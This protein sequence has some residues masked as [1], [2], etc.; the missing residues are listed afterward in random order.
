MVRRTPRKGVRVGAAAGEAAGEASWVLGAGVLAGGAGAGVDRVGAA[1]A[2]GAGEVDRG[3]SCGGTDVLLGD[4]ACEAG[5]RDGVDFDAEVAR[6]AAHSGGGEGFAGLGRHAS[7]FAADR[8]DDGAGVLPLGLGGG[9]LRR[10][11]GTVAGGLGDKFVEL[12]AEGRTR[13]RTPRCRPR[14]RVRLRS[15]RSPWPWLARA[16]C[17]PLS[18]VPPLPPPPSKVTRA[19]PTWRTS[20]SLPWRAAMT[21]V[22]GEG[23][24]TRAL[25]VSISARISCSLTVWPTA[26]RHLMSSASWTPSP[27]SGEDEVVGVGGGLGVS[28]G[29]PRGKGQGRRRMQRGDV[30]ACRIIAG[31]GDG[32]RGVCYFLKAASLSLALSSASRRSRP[33]TQTTSLVGAHSTASST[34]A[35]AVRPFGRGEI[36]AAGVTEIH[37]DL[38]VLHLRR[39][40]GVGEERFEG[41]DQVVEEVLVDDREGGGVGGE[42][43]LDAAEG[44]LRGGDVRQF[45]EREL[46]VPARAGRRTGCPRRLALEDRQ[47]EAFGA[48]DAADFIAPA[49]ERGSVETCGGRCAGWFW[50]M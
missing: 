28:H 7:E 20:P 21:P 16:A 25:S 50:R 1:F 34:R 11:V 5:A 17:P 46:D 9:G 47:A 10:R 38:G 22:R 49:L 43:D 2:A 35:F 44:F 18:A 33:M 3:A 39:L 13:R 15:W 36:E 41:G 23:T 30:I 8:T 48:D 40:L 42:A 31:W 19:F 27:R 14:W 24:S 12:A 6:E 4:S 26:T 29:G 45:E 32:S 37:A